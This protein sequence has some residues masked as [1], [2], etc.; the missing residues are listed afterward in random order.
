MKLASL[1]S[2]FNSRKFMDDTNPPGYSKYYFAYEGGIFTY[3]FFNNKKRYPD[4]RTGV[5]LLCCDAM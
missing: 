5:F 4:L 1:S 3:T 2:S